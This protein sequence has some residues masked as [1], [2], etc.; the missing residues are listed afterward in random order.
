[1]TAVDRSRPGASSALPVLYSRWIADLLPDPV[2]PEPR[3]TCASCAMV[4][5]TAPPGQVVSTET[6]FEAATKCCTFLP[7]LPSFLVGAALA[8]QDATHAEGR[9]TVIDRI[10]A[11]DS[12]TPLGLGRTAAFTARYY[13]NPAWFG[14]DLQIKCPHLLGD[15]RC[16]VW[17]YREATC[18]TWFCK[19]ER[20][21]VSKRFWRAL[22][23][24]LSD[25]EREV[26]MWCAKE[27]GA[28]SDPLARI[29]DG[30]AFGT[31][32]T[33]TDEDYRALW[34][35]WFG[36]EQELYLAAAKLVA[37]MRW[38]DVATIA[39]PDFADRID[40]LVET[41]D[42]LESNAMPERLEKGDVTLI[43][44]GATSGRVTG[45]S[46][47]DPR[48]VPLEI[49]E[50]VPDADGLTVDAF[51]EATGADLAQIRALLDD[52]I[53]LPWSPEPEPEPKDR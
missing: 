24:L 42:A 33:S 27:L 43:Q 26:A 36:R 13:S 37:P 19:H 44:I 39:G 16:G 3:A 31:E 6:R 41:L 14:R 12:V 34:G 30:T 18:A 8:D 50:R 15:G 52:E 25:L 1:M 9:Q 45:Y 46:E 47:F 17:N 23:R 11:R 5:T 28:Y 4:S 29:H 53:L 32:Y 10:L 7:N 40:E 20:G 21:L 22:Q 51:R 48:E 2:L 49:L 35:S 38:V